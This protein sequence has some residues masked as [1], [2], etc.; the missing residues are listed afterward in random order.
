[1]QLAPGVAAYGCLGCDAVSCRYC[2]SQ[3]FIRAGTSKQFEVALRRQERNAALADQH[4]N[5]GAVYSTREQCDQIALGQRS[6]LRRAWRR[7]RNY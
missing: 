7:W 4:R 2:A 5:A 6:F 3:L 1:L